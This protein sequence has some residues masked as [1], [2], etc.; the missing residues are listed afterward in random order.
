METLI[1]MLDMCDY[2]VASYSD[3]MITVVDQYYNMTTGEV[4]YE[5]VDLP[6]TWESVREFCL[7]SN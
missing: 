1:Q 7:A 6:A 3:D 5:L 4:E 2:P